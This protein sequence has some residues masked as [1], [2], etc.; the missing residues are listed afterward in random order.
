MIL[1]LLFRER[2]PISSR[3]NAVDFYLVICVFL[4]FTALMEYA[5]ILLL[6]KKQRKPEYS[7]NAGLK[8]MFNNGDAVTNTRGTGASSPQSAL[9]EAK[10]MTVGESGDENEVQ[11]PIRRKK[12]KLLAIDPP[13]DAHTKAICDNIDAWAMWLS[14]PLFIIFNI[15]YWF[16]YQ[17]VDVEPPEPHLFSDTLT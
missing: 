8:K 9:E 15:A 7:I 11:A 13:V 5:V 4:V 6:L 16:A 1:L 12:V 3:L 14:P 17:H 2:A 10:R